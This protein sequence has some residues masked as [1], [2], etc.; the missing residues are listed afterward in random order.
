LTFGDSQ[1][2]L[3]IAMRSDE[4]RLKILTSTGLAF[5]VTVI[6]VFLALPDIAITD[7]G[8]YATSSLLFPYAMLSLHAFGGDKFPLLFLGL[9]QFFIYG[10]LLAWA[11]I[12]GC[13]Q[14]VALRLLILHIILGVGCALIYIADPP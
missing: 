7:R 8:R 12:R 1:P 11:W 10:A 13:E 9:P 3:I 5:A 6:A 14:K 2:T 4:S